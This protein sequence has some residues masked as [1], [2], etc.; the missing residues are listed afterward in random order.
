[1]G[2]ASPF[3]DIP[4]SWKP[5]LEAARAGGTLFL[6]GAIDS[7]K[8]TL[9]AVLANE[10]HAA[11]RKVAVVD[12]DMGQSSIGPPA[13]VGMGLLKERIGSLEELSPLAIDFVG[14]C[15]PVGHLL[16]TA[17]S[18]AAMA[19]AARE[20]GADTLIVDTTGLVTGGIARALKG[21]KIRLLDPDL[22]IALQKKDELEPLLTPYRTRIRPPVLVLP[23]SKVV[24]ARSREQ[25]AAN[26]QRKFAAYVRD[27]HPLALSWEDAPVENS[28]WTS[29]E[30]MPGPM[31]AYAEECVA[32]EVLHAERRPDGVFLIVSGSPDLAGLRKLADNFGAARAVEVSSLSNLLVGLLGARGETLALG[33]LESVDYKQ[34]RMTV[35]T[36]WIEAEAVKGVRL[37]AIQLARDGA[38]LAA[39]E[40]G[41]TG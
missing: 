32:C 4:F 7:G 10:A 40:P 13:C 28:A 1:M 23:L 19:R 14:A 26:R 16:Q 17:T 3:L 41:A 27:A 12:A 36:P 18:A 21:A 39:G 6:I 25:R 29:G 24:K 11:G 34:K 8:S 15:S 9:A 30:P 35:Y 20:T 31:C 38:Q 5:A 33:L 2:T 22:I 37:G